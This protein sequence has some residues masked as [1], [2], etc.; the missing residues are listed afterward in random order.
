MKKLVTILLVT[1]MLFSLVACTAQETEQDQGATD[2]T[3]PEVS[4]DAQPTNALTEEPDDEEEV[5]LSGK[6]TIW[7]SGEELGRFK[8]GF[9]EVYPDIEVEITVVP[10]S[11]F[12]A[13]ITPTLSS[14]QDAPDIFT[15][16]SDYVKYLVDSPYWDDL[17]NYG[18]DEYTSDIWDYVLSVGTD[19]NGVVKALSWQASPGSVMYRRDI[20]QDVFGTDDSAEISALLSSNEKMMEAA[21]TL[22]DNGIKMFASWQDIFNMQFSNRSK[23]WVENETLTIDESMFDFMDMAKTI[24]ENGYD[25]NADPWSG[26]WFAAVEGDDTFC[27]VLPTWGYQFVVKPSAVN[28]IGKWA[29]AEGPVPYVKGGTWLGIYKDSPNKQLAWRFLEYVCCNTEAQQ[30]YSMEYGEYVSL[31]SADTALAEGE[32]EEVLGGQNLYAFFND[33]MSKI[34]NDL[35]TPYDGQ[36]NNAFLS[37]VKAYATGA[38]TKDEAITTF[39]ED[40][41]T[42]YPDIA[43]N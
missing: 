28:T 3:E 21:A 34:P 29:L 35:M 4:D 32:G 20:A 16:E 12:I 24:S 37:A 6:I 9:N 17:S 33:Q 40:V 26:E 19:K 41:T 18:V 2:A 11:E 23:P 30:A 5:P 42:A 8:E 14:G 22:G 38:M 27:Y 36:I 7:S 1:V 25:L 31:K 43:V 10:N 39:K 15:G 13:K